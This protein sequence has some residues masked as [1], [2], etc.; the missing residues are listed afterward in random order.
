MRVVQNHR[1]TEQA[2]WGRRC[3]DRDPTR[4]PPLASLGGADQRL[5]PWAPFVAPRPAGGN[6]EVLG[7]LC[8]F[9]ILP[10][11]TRPRRSLAGP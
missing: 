1:F 4:L 11:F 6:L 7:T 2:Q 8:S 3:D 9:S 10:R 5:T